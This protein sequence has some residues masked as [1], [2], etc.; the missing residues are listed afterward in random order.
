MCQADAPPA[1]FVGG[2]GAREVSVSAICLRQTIFM[3]RGGQKNG[4]QG[5][6]TNTQH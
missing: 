1:F 3:E 4:R 2:P 6:E 5:M